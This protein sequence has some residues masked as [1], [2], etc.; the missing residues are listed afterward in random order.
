MQIT[1]LETIRVG[2]FPNL[3]FVRVHSDAG[4]V[5]LGETF[6]GAAAV[7]AYLHET[8]SGVL[9]GADPLRIDRIA[10]ALRPYVGVAGSGAETRGNSAVDVALW[11]LFGQ[12][13]GLPVNQLLGGATRDEVRIYNTCAGYRYIRE[14]PVQAVA[15]WGLPADG[16]EGP[17]EDLDGFLHRPAELARD[18]LAEGVSAMKIWPFD[19]FAERWGGQY[20]AP[21]ELAE[22]L[23]PFAA[24]RRAV[25]DEMDIMVE[26]HGLWNLPTAKRIVRA[27]APYAPFWIEDPLRPPLVTASLQELASV[28]AAPLTLSET[29]AGRAAFLPLLEQ[30]LLGVAMLDVAWCGG[31]SE[32]KKIATLAETYQVPVAPHDCT[33][34]VVLTASTHL[35]TNVVNGFIQETVRAFYH[36]WYR[37]L[38]TE[39][40]PIEHGYIRPPE[41][42][43]LGTALRPEVLERPDA[44][45]RRSVL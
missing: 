45:V 41:G 40:P 11:D 17:Y 32:A 25:G 7:E 4:L 5:G 38:V 21:G 37:E 6:M 24:I 14:R 30:G 31:L 3:C 34:P 26:L 39:L 18:L 1:S 20:I 2:E 27:L 16:A 19:R 33:G 23:A 44:V 36:G 10:A 9:L 29:L 8:A 12:A 22:A 13:A 43:G 35:A 28:S 42:P 15:N